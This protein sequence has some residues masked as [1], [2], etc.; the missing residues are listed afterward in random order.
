MQGFEAMAIDQTL[1][2]YDKGFVRFM[3]REVRNRVTEIVVARDRRIRHR[4]DC[5]PM[6]ER[7]LIA[8]GARRQ[9]DFGVRHRNR[10]AVAVGR[11]MF[12]A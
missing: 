3:N 11:C 8:I 4:I 2:G 10:I 5:Q 9:M 7:R 1:G 6:F 12:Y